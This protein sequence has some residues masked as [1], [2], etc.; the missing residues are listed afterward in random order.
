[1]FKTTL[2]TNEV[3]VY[4]KVDFGLDRDTYIKAKYQFIGFC[5]QDKPKV[6]PI[7]VARPVDDN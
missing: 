1:M 7:A 5:D 2:L 4:P 6:K 3:V